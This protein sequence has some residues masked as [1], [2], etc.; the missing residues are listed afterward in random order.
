[1]KKLTEVTIQDAIEIIRAGYSNFFFMDRGKW[2]IEDRSKEI[3]EPTKLIFN[4]SK[5][6]QFW[7][8]ND[9]IDPSYIDPDKDAPGFDQTNF[10]CKF[11][12]YLKANELGYFVPGLSTKS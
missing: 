4:K 11:P 3:G 8:H 2:I 9:S 5:I 7:F 10:D 12:C 1:M 6:L